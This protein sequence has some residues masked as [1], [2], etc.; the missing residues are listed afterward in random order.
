M[1]N[2]YLVNPNACP[3]KATIPPKVTGDVIVQG[4]I[5]YLQLFVDDVLCDTVPLQE[6]IDKIV[7]PESTCDANFDL[8]TCTHTITVDGNECPVNL[9]PLLTQLEI[10]YNPA[11]HSLVR[12][13]KGNIQDIQPINCSQLGFD[14]ATCELWHI[15]EKGNRVS[16]FI[17]RDRFI[18][19]ADA[20][21]MTI[22][23]AKP[24]DTPVTFPVGVTED[25]VSFGMVGKN[26]EFVYKDKKCTV[27]LPNSIIG[28][29]HNLATNTL[30]FI[31]CDGTEDVK[32]LPK[33]SLTC[34]TLDDG[35]R[36][37]VFDNGCPG[38]Q[39]VWNVDPMVMDIDNLTVVDSL[40]TFTFGGDGNDGVVTLD[41]C[42]IVAT[43][44]NATITAQNP[45]GSWSFV[46]NAGNPFNFPAPANCCTYFGNNPTVL[47]GAN[48][49]SP[50]GAWPTKTNGDTA[51]ECHPNGLSFWT[52]VAGAW[53][54]NYTKIF[55]DCCHYQVNST[56]VIDPA[57]PPA[58]PPAISGKADRDTAHVCHPNGS[59]YY[60]CVN[61][62]WVLDF[63]KI[64][65][66]APADCCHYHA[67]AP[68]VL[69]PASPPTA[70]NV[71]DPT[72]GNKSNGDTLHVCH[73][74]GS[75]YYTC[76]NG[77]WVFDYC[78]IDA[79]H[80]SPDGSVDI[81]YNATTNTWEYSVEHP[82]FPD[83]PNVPVF[84][85]KDGG[86][87]TNGDVLLQPSDFAFAGT[88]PPANA[89]LLAFGPND[90]CVAYEVPGDCC[91]YH[92]I[93]TTPFDPENPPATPGS[94]P[95]GVVKAVGNTMMVCHPNGFCAYTCAAGGWQLDWCKS[96]A[97]DV[98][99]EVHIGD[100]QPDKT[101]NGGNIKVWFNCNDGCVYYCQEDGTWLAP[102]GCPQPVTDLAGK[103][104][105]RGA[106]YENDEG[107]TVT[108]CNFEDDGI[109]TGKQVDEYL[110]LNLEFDSA[111][112]AGIANP[113][114][115]TV[116]GSTGSND[117]DGC[118][119]VFQSNNST[120]A[121][122]HNTVD[123]GNNV[124]ILAGQYNHASGQGNTLETGNNNHV[125]G[126]NN[127][128]ISGNHNHVAG[129][130]NELTASSQNNLAG[131]GNTYDGSSGNQGAGTNNT[132]DNADFS[133]LGGSNNVGT[134]VGTSVIGGA[135]NQYTDVGSTLGVGGPGNVINSVIQSVIGGGNITVDNSTANFINGVGNDVD[136]VRFSMIVGGSNTFADSNR[137]IVYGINNEV[138]NGSND[139]STG[140][141]E[142]L[143]DGAPTSV[144]NG[145]R[146]CIIGGGNNHITASTNSEING[147]IRA[148]ILGSNGVATDKS[149]V[150]TGGN[151]PGGIKDTLN[152]RWE[153]DSTTGNVNISGTLTTGFVFP[154]FGEYAVVDKK[155]ESG[156]FLV[157][158][159]THKARVAKANEDF[160]GV[161]RIEIP[162][163]AGGGIDPA[164]S[165]WLLDDM[166]NRIPVDIE[167]TDVVNVVDA[168]AT[169]KAQ[170]AANKEVDK[171]NKAGAKNPE[172]IAEKYVPVA[173]VLKEEEVVTVQQGYERNPDYDPEAQAKIKTVGVSMMGRVWIQTGEDVEVGDYLRAG[174]GGKGFKSDERTRAKVL[175][176]KEGAAFVALR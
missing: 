14:L 25:Q 85:D 131:G 104:C 30:T 153:L 53:V 157:Y 119:G 11:T 173:E 6:L 135:N 65:P 55:A 71:P 35:T 134:N 99:P 96:L 122:S 159:G 38:G 162:M 56:T 8:A 47:G 107:A 160:D 46:D 97:P 172:F 5:C 154:D 140:G 108:D 95:A 105:A 41:I 127:T 176:V 80:D 63:C 143:M 145:F 19:N 77:A 78:K 120:V 40:L 54:L 118:G 171:R 155:I 90:E 175:E 23:P 136:D 83:I 72:G 12:R 93:T 146:N 66:E 103:S 147:F 16:W 148:A 91:H 123:S 50:A 174:R 150:V 34:S 4:N 158:E 64:D 156:L 52:C 59:C 89:K 110:D 21:Q 2:D 129:F 7:H 121:G 169:K 124:N 43:H 111:A 126:L 69:N 39:K 117:A 115:N 17:P 128:I 98:P 82:D 18:Y 92:A 151:V 58:T 168:A 1:A 142:N 87:I 79:L 37:F 9:A 137:S 139:S 44:C 166:G 113:C 94:V 81:S 67:Q 33:A 144:M 28:C 27:P 75:C 138:I 45:D 51:V 36:V 133:T 73:P 88:P 3:S 20:C 70:P 164:N 132:W 60:S 32:N 116:Q 26:L 149:A 102:K 167:F 84:K 114:C 76:V 31:H 68:G 62:A 125:N 152:R 170:A 100:D 24:G 57:A 29:E 42:D 106:V 130:A 163:A 141:A 61:G 86:D 13:V 74:N 10:D 112:L 22:I 161:S 48:P 49:P 109:P 101:A 165:P 15:N